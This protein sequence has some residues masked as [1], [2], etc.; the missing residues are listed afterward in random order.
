M[1]KINVHNTSNRN[2]YYLNKYK[3]KIIMLIRKIKHILKVIK[4]EVEFNTSLLKMVFH[5]LT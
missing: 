4:R 3:L 5:N 1:L 2:F